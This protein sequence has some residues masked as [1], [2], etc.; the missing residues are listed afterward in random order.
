MIAFPLE[1][2]QGKRLLLT[3]GT[4]FVGQH[5][6]RALSPLAESGQIEISC[7][8]RASSR[9]AA[10]PSFVRVFEADLAT[11]KGLAE[12]LQGQHMVVHMAALL[13]GV[14]W[15][16]YLSNVQAA[17]LLGR[18]IAAEQAQN[19]A[20][21]RV[22][23]VSSLAATGPCAVAPGMDDATMAQPVSA[24]G[25]SKYLSEEALGRHC[26]KSLVVLRP[27]MI[28]GP[29]DAGLLPYFVMAKKGLVVSP[30]FG[31]DFPVSIMHVQDVVQA[32]LCLLKPEAHGVYHCNDGAVHT[33]QTVGE[34]MASLMGK[35]ARC[36]RMPLAIMSVS[37]VFSTLWGA[38]TQGVGLRA[39]SWNLDKYR[40][41][42]VAGWLCS[43]TRL[44]E[45]LGFSPSMPLRE[46][47]SQ[48]IESYK[49]AGKL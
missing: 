46:G 23:M 19:G 13:F 28:Y 12:A 31:R 1:H 41:A 3:G 4:G 10:L 7:L 22:V 44:Q 18:A 11:G 30:G 14:A 36:L 17:S 35:K 47:L 43:S 29:G 39:P 26:G 27:P 20:L 15:Q 6:L 32:I 40:E 24:Y 16:D 8:V 34:L 45:E 25:W 37:A 38:A 2:M 42:R 5:V 9:R 21:E 48:T 33:M 49:Q